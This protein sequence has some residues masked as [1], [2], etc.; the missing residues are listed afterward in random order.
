MTKEARNPNAQKEGK[1][2]RGAPGTPSPRR[3]RQPRLLIGPQRRLTTPDAVEKSWPELASSRRMFLPLLGERAGVRAG[4]SVH[5]AVTFPR[6]SHEMAPANAG[7]VIRAS[8][9]ILISTFVVGTT[10]LP[11]RATT[12][13][14]STTTATASDS[15]DCGTIILRRIERIYCNVAR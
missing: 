8:F 13:N 12:A 11:P 7:F 10:A 3:R 5:S 2:K 15:L 4:V 1:T 6:R 14:G 9:G